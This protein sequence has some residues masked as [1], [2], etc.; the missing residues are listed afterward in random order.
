MGSFFLLGDFTGGLLSAQDL[1]RERCECGSMKMHGGG[2]GLG[3]ER[4]PAEVAPGRE[5]V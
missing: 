1:Q 2:L 3:R 4:K 5:S